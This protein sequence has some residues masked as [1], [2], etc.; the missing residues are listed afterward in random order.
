MKYPDLNLLFTNYKSFGDT[1]SG[2]EKFA[3]TNIIIGRNN[4]GKSALLDIVEWAC[5]PKNGIAKHLWHGRNH[6][7]ITYRTTV[8]E[9]SAR[10]VF[11]ANTSGGTLPGNHWQ[12]G[13]RLVGANLEVLLGDP[14]KFASIE[15]PLEAASEAAARQYYEALSAQI[16]NP[17]KGKH[18]RRLS[19]ERDIAPEG[20]GN[21]L[22]IQK[23]GAGFT[24][25]VAQVLTKFEHPSAIVSEQMLRALNE[26]FAPDTYFESINVQQY[27]QG[28]WEIFL[29]ERGNIEI[30]LSHSGSGLKTILIVIGFFYLLPYVQNAE[31]SKFIFAFEELENNLHPALQRRLLKFVTETARKNNV[32]LL[33]TTHSNVVIDL[34]S[35]DS[36][37][38]LLHVAHQNGESTVRRVQTYVDNR[39][40]L[41]DL[42]VRASDL[43]QSNALIWVEGP[44]DRLYF[45]RWMELFTDGEIKEGA[46]YQCVYYGGRLLAHLS[47]S[48][49]TV[50]ADDVVKILNVNRNAILLI[51]SDK[52][53]DTDT[54]NTTKHRLIDETTK[55]GG[56]AW[57]T[58]GR[59]IE[60]YLPIS[61]LKSRL[62]SASRDLRQFEDIADYLEQI[63]PSA[64]KKFERSKVLFAESV[65]PFLEKAALESRLDW[66]AQMTTVVERIRGWNGLTTL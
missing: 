13:K 59:E 32:L 25:T 48:D 42:D 11:P 43:L 56:Y 37:A 45:N 57:A 21:Q 39:G 36:E 47:A 53:D 12:V 15:R 66:A 24:N 50:D 20:A 17:F 18:F 65:I 44:S 46:H 22:Q 58:N 8:T 7:R 38:Q 54:M 27:E 10:Q 34:F 41:D 1:P 26:I 6:P 5:N 35:R 2:F 9:A 60:N 4:S 3:E 64:G 55:A 51:D 19:A 63:E 14:P 62:P 31:L 49:P 23:N 33:L 28:A 40:I 16:S 61:A 52:S 29:K 30:A